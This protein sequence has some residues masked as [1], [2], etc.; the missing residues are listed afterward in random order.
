[1]TE[2]FLGDMVLTD[3]MDPLNFP[4]P[5]CFSSQPLTLADS[6]IEKE[7]SRKPVLQQ[8][9]DCFGLG[10]F[11]DVF[12]KEVHSRWHSALYMHGLYVH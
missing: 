7:M 8:D 12:D 11:G 3:D 9:A 6:P 2:S 5:P 10:S 1:M 4:D